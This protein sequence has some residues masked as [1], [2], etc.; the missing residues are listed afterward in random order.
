MIVLMS[1][2]LDEIFLEKLNLPVSFLSENME[3]ITG[4][5]FDWVPKTSAYEDAW[6]V[7][8]SLLQE[9]IKTD[10]PIVIY[11]RYL[12]LS[13]KEVEWVNKFN[14]KLFEPALNS[15]RSGF[16]YLPEWCSNFE[17]VIDDEDRIF[18]LVYSHHE[19]EFNIRNFEKWFVDYGRLFPEKKVVYSAISISDFKK[20]E[21][22]SNNL[23]YLDHHHPIFNEGNFTVAIDKNVMY[24]IG[25]FN[26]M[27][28][29]AMNLGCLPLLPFEHKY[30][31]GMFKGLV[32]QNLNDMDY[33]ISTFGKVKDVVIEELFDEIKDK[34]NEFTVDHAADIIRKCYE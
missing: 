3:D 29:Y 18:D 16:Q 19:L 6:M 7:Q 26:P 4:L 32:I 13:E 31:H 34:W 8:A 24:D 33:Y 11:D 30:F 20:E 27:Y 5:F 1:N 22:K 23:T 10:I 14:V 12:S 9:H 21:Y 25:H 2:R 15:G 28:F 17:I